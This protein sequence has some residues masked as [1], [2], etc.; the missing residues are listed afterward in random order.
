MASCFDLEEVLQRLD[1]DD[2]GLFSDD[3]SDFEGDGVV[4]YLPEV[5]DEHLD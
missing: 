1:D 4:R 3:E 5:Q 2:F